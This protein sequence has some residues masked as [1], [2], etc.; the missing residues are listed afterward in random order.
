[1]QHLR[2]G[3]AA[4]I[5]FTV[6]TDD[7]SGA[8]FEQCGSRPSSRRGQVRCDCAAGIKLA[9]EH[10][11]VSWL[12]REAVTQPRHGDRIQPRC[13]NLFQHVTLFYGRVG[14]LEM[15]GALMA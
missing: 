2:K 8:F 1:M 13:D 10:C 15:G 11:A 14:L 5:G 4:G 12:K 6:N 9:H 7:K 3:T